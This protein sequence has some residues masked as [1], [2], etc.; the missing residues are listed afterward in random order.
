MK[1]N[2]SNYFKEAEK[3]NKKVLYKFNVKLGPYNIFKKYIGNMF[4]TFFSLEENTNKEFIYNTIKKVE[5]IIAPGKSGDM[6]LIY[7]K[8]TEYLVRDA[9]DI[10]LNDFNF[11]STLTL[12]YYKILVN[13][14]LRCSYLDYIN[15]RTSA[16]FDIITKTIIDIYGFSILDMDADNSL[17][18]QIDWDK[19][20][21]VLHEK[22]GM[23]K[24]KEID[25][26][27][28]DLWSYR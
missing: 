27:L 20:E 23:L 13:S 18:K 1:I 2:S 22:H 15:K 17:N 6:S 4:Q 8:Y 5:D 26:D 19:L 25:I 3:G 9:V 28:S 21:E 14:D 16:K 11:F 7:D 24:V 12:E 10:K